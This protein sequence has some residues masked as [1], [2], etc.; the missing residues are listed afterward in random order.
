MRADISLAEKFAVPVAIVIVA[1]AVFVS[2]TA[3]DVGMKVIT[4][5]G[6]SEMKVAADKATMSFSIESEAVTAKESQQENT[7]VSNLVI[8]F[9]SENLPLS[10]FQT[11]QL[12]VYPVTEYNPKTGEVTQTGYKTTHM[13]TVETSQIDDVGKIIDGV[14]DSGAN[15]VDQVSFSLSDDREREIRSQILD[16]AAVQAK[17]KA[18]SIASGLGARIVG[19]RSASE[20]SFYVTPFYSRSEA[21]MAKDVMGGQTQVAQGEVDVSASV[22]A[23]FEI[24]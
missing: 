12:T 18:Q 8:A 5:T 10:D 16:E 21:V 13:I 24:A 4:A 22:S 17:N 2:S 14:I 11:A 1:I 23:S 19:V 6:S 15:R 3:S 20:S 7:R 9:L